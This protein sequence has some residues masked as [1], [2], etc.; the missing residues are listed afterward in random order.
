M[1]NYGIFTNFCVLQELMQKG[2]KSSK[3]EDKKSKLQ[4]SRSQHCFYV[5]TQGP[6]NWQRSYVAKEYSMSRHREHEE[7]RNSVATQLTAT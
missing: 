4:Q 7:G 5:A 2:K 6:N 3:K 1:L